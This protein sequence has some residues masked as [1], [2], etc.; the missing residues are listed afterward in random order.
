MRLVSFASSGVLTVG[1]ATT[2]ARE[3]IVGYL[4]RKDFINEFTNG[5]DAAADK[6]KAIKEFYALLANTGFDVKV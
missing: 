3:V 2:M 4:R 5:L 1:K 6:E